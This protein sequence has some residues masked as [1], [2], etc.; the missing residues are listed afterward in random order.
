[1]LGISGL[2][3]GRVDVVSPVRVGEL[4]VDLARDLDGEPSDAEEQCDATEGAQAEAEAER[5]PLWALCP[6]AVTE[7]E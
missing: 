1:M 2:Q 5:G 3:E 4:L 6:G 7:S